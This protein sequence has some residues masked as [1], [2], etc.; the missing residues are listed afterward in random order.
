MPPHHYLVKSATNF[1]STPLPSLPSGLLYG[2]GVFTT[3]AIAPDSE[4]FKLR[5]HYER[6]KTGGEF[7]HIAFPWHTFEAFENNLQSFIQSTL[8]HPQVL[9]ITLTPHHHA[10]LSPTATETQILLSLRPFP[11][12]NHGVKA[13]TVKFNRFFPQHKHISHIAEKKYLQIAQEQGYDDYI[14]ISED[15]YL[16]EAAYANLFLISQQN[17]LLAPHPEQAGCLPGIMREAIIEACQEI[18]INVEEGLY[19]LKDIQQAKGAF[20]SN[21]V[22]GAYPVYSINDIEYDISLTESL[23]TKLKRH[24]YFHNRF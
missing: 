17:R 5:R 12:K 14:R 13:C 8:H 20:L 3:M 24:P 21:A 9:R 6:L 4:I 7:F 15:G 22:R 23:L 19:T 2:E 10:N 11:K 18:G 1:E 16:T